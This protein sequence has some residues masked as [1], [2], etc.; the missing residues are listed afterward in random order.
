MQPR[1]QKSRRHGWSKQARYDRARFL[2]CWVS[3]YNL[4]RPYA[5][6]ESP[7]NIRSKLIVILMPC[8]ARFDNSDSF[9]CKHIR[10]QILMSWVGYFLAPGR[11]GPVE[12]DSSWNTYH[13]WRICWRGKSQGDVVS[14]QIWV[15]CNSKS[16]LSKHQLV[17]LNT[18]TRG[19][20]SPFQINPGKRCLR[21]GMGVQKGPGVFKFGSHE[22]N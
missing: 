14:N 19:T 7:W 15:S 11:P 6:S 16:C 21:T 22:K 5:V 2:S 8:T 1:H 3:D 18:C 9:F 17:S 12:R 20:R 4:K 13:R 10:F